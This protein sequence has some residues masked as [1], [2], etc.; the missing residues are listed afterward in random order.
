MIWWLIPLVA[1][2][3]AWAYTRLAWSWRGRGRSRPEPGS[4]QDAAD[5]ARFAEALHR[6][7]PG[8]RR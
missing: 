1:T 2:F 8:G 3:A 5:L 7:M 4:P 6:P